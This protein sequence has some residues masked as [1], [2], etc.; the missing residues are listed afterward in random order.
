MRTARIL[1]AAGVLLYAGCARIDAER[2]STAEDLPEAERYGGTAVIG[3]TVDIDDINPIT[4]K[5]GYA[6]DLQRFVLFTPLLRYNEHLE[7]EPYGA[8]AWEV[9][10]DTTELT[11]HLRDD[12]YWHDGIKTTAE[13]WKF[14]YDLARDL[15]AAFLYP[16]YWKHY[17]E[18]EAVD[19]F[20]FRVKMRPHAELLDPWTAFSPVP[21]HILQGVPAEQLKSH[22]FS[23]TR[24]VGNGPFR[25]VSRVP[26]QSWTF[27]A[28]PDFPQ[29]LGG[30]PY[31][32]RLV[33]RSIPEQT[34]LLT[35]LLTG[36]IDF[37]VRLP[38]DQAERIQNSGV[39]RIADYLDRAYMH[40]E[41][42]HRRAPFDDARVRQALT[43]AIN[44]GGAARLRR[45]GQ[46]SGPADVLAV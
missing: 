25:F 2:A 7:V 15:K 35:E 33:Y 12:L 34:T 44:R 38:A 16:A 30:R 22:P 27:E 29:A 40:V 28:N 21:R 24:P 8:K 5:N 4:W 41:W 10:A 37:Y 23:H 14:S 17:G 46:L 36:G 19:S 18:A 13:D 9:N 3:F 31:L 11:F 32:D 20:T 45:G 42:N 26:G 39:A 1:V 43:L 6:Q